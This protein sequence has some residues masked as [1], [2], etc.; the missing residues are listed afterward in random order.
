MKPFIV[1]AAVLFLTAICC[2]C[3][4]AATTLPDSSPAPTS[5][6]ETAPVATPTTVPSDSP[7]PLSTNPSEWLGFDGGNPGAYGL[8]CGSDDGY[9]YYRSEED[10]RLWRAKPDGSEKTKICD[11]IPEHINVLGD[12]VYFICHSDDNAIY[13]VCTDGTE[14]TKLAEGYCTNLF[15]AESG[16]YFDIR[17]ENN[18]AQAYY[19]DLDGD[20]MVNLISDCYIAYY[21]DGKIYTRGAT[22][23][24]F[25]VY[26]VKTGEHKILART[27]VHNVSVDDSG[28]YYWAVNEG[29]FRLID[30]GGNEK[31]LQQ[32]GDYYNYTR[33]FLYYMGYG[34]NKNGPCH[35]INKLNVTT[36]ETT[37]L[38]EELN[39]FFDVHGEFIGVT[40]KQLETGDYDPDIFEDTPYGKVLKGGEN[41]FNEAVSFIY[42]AGENVYIKAGLRESLKQKGAL[43]C[44]ARLDGGLVIWD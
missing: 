15:A 41:Y 14:E 12:W 3:G 4:I 11:Q 1:I 17:D 16:L 31:T 36:G 25:G 37:T 18:V 10:W 19:A 35:V 38:Y 9:I 22:E 2:G 26:E 40:Y 13:K 32:G 24:N 6:T 7:I 34:E 39:E 42:V 5:A 44:I 30:S 23:H 21:Y 27:Y 28:I 20:R 29:E 33:G 43:D 8:M